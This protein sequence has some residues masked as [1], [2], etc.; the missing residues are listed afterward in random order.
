MTQHAARPNGRKTAAA[1]KDSAAAKGDAT[2]ASGATSAKPP[3]P[4]RAA[5][6]SAKPRLSIVSS[7][8]TT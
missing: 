6:R 8:G 1:A 3:R 5:K 4:A 7:N 2:G